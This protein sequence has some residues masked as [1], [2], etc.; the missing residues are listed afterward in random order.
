QLRDALLGQVSLVRAEA[1]LQGREA[2]WLFPWPNDHATRAQPAPGTTPP[3]VFMLVS[4]LRVVPAAPAKRRP[5][6]NAAHGPT[7]RRLEV[8]GGRRAAGA[9]VGAT[10]APLAGHHRQGVCPR[11]PWWG[12]GRHE[13]AGHPAVRTDP[14]SSRKQRP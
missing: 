7:H 6:P 12:P 2:T 4:K 10:G 14:Q 3:N 5:L 1:A 9:G 8:A 11:A 13:P